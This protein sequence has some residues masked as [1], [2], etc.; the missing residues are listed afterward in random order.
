MKRR[1]QYFKWFCGN[2]GDEGFDILVKTRMAQRVQKGI[3][4]ELLMDYLLPDADGWS[5]PKCCWISS[6]MSKLLYFQH[7]EKR[8]KCNENGHLRLSHK[9]NQSG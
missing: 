5:F 7:I 2:S 6:R 8:R 4:G 9:P 1:H 3:S